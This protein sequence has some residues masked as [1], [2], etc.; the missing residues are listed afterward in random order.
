M[1]EKSENSTKT[2]YFGISPGYAGQ[3][4]CDPLNVHHLHYGLHHCGCQGKFIMITYL[5]VR[6]TVLAHICAYYSHM[7]LLAHICEYDNWKF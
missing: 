5:S 6:E 3:S 7:C 4:L 2:Q 1:N